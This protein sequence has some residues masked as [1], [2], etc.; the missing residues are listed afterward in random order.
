VNSAESLAL[1][2]RSALLLLALLLIL[3]LLLG[4]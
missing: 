1:M 3:P 4:L 2:L